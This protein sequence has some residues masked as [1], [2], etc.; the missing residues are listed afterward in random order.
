MTHQLRKLMWDR[1][2]IVRTNAQLEEALE[3]VEAVKKEI[4]MPDSVQ[5]AFLSWELT[6]FH[7]LVTVCELMTRCALL[8]RESRGVHY[9]LDHLDRASEAKN[10]ILSP[11]GRF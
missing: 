1:V 11:K 10:S 3:E 7:N 5:Q 6:Q 9:N 2:G 8:R 4:G